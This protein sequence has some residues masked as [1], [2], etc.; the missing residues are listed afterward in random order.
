MVPDRVSQDWEE[1]RDR[2]RLGRNVNNN[3]V[4]ETDRTQHNADAVDF[5]LHAFLDVSI[6]LTRPRNNLQDLRE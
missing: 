4:E 3:D 2:R 1:P 5:H 6:S